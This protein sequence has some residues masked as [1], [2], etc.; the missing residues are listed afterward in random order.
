M[1]AHAHIPHLREILIF[2]VAAGLAVPLL[3]RRMGA[4]LGYL[5]LGAI[6]GPFGLGLLADQIPVLQMIVITKLDGVRAL[7]ELGIV[8]LLFTIGLELSL[9]RVWGMR[10]LVFGLGSAQILATASIIGLVAFAWGNSP[11]AAM[12]LGACLALSSTAIVTQLL[13]EGRRLS[14]PVGRTAFSVLL[15]QDLAVVPILFAVGILATVGNAGT[16]TTFGTAIAQAAGAAALV[17]TAG[18]LLLRPT[19]RFVAS[20]QS[21]EAFMGIVLLLAIGTAALTSYAGLSMAPGAFLAGLLIAETE[22]RHQVEVDIEPFKGLMLGLFFMSV[23]M[24]IDWRFIAEQPIL[25]AASVIGLFVLKSVIT[26]V[27]GILWRLPRHQAVE[28]GL[29]LGQAGEFAFIL[30]G[31]ATGSNLMPAPTGQFMLI[32]ASLTMLLTPTVA[33]AAR[34]VS[35]MLER[36]HAAR[37]TDQT[38]SSELEDHIIIAGYGRVGR[39]IGAV[40][41]AEQ[42]EFVAIDS[43]PEI[44]AHA[45]HVGIPVRFGDASRLEVLKAAGIDHAGALVITTGGSGKVA[46]HLTARLREVAPH[47]PIYARARD[48]GHAKRLL[49]AG[50]TAAIPE[51]VE[52]SLQLASRVLS[53]CGTSEDVIDHRIKLQRCALETA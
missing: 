7:A 4:V 46:E 26:M 30:V 43:D 44:A 12:V 34:H 21:R 51:T 22:Y 20:T 39:T 13:V 31:L 17:Y 45:R 11:T 2:L 5:V 37:H 53:G 6:I 47:V 10:R 8:F 52:G 18:R 16:A 24:G 25:I 19:L 49:E 15:M 28:V 23:G 40:L 35:G 27:L 48:S 38:A 9:E 50:A 1:E 33:G 32:V 36:Q 29:L 3:Q 14:T 41:D 42:L